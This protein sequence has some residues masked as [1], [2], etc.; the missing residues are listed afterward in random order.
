MKFV[1]SV[2]I[3]RRLKIIGSRE[4]FSPCVLK[5][6]FRVVKFGMGVGLKRA[7]PTPRLIQVT[8]RL[9]ADPEI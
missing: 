1:G 8:T 9:C 4:N 5:H 6:F 2:W 3:Y 7:D